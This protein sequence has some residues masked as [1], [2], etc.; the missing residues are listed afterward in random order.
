MIHLRLLRLLPVVIVVATFALFCGCGKTPAP[1]PTTSTTVGPPTLPGLA[2]RPAPADPKIKVDPLVAP[3]KLS[4][5]VVCWPAENAREE[6]LGISDATVVVTNLGEK[7]APQANVQPCV[8]TDKNGFFQSP[9]PSDGEYSVVVA[10]RGGRRYLP[11]ELPVFS[12]RDGKPHTL[13]PVVLSDVLNEDEPLSLR[14]VHGKLAVVAATAA[15]LTEAGRESLMKEYISWRD[16]VWRVMNEPRTVVVP[17]YFYPDPKKLEDWDRILAAAEKYKDRI[18]FR[19]ILNPNSGPPKDGQLDANYEA[20][21]KRCQSAHVSLLGYLAVA[22]QGDAQKPGWQLRTKQLSDDLKKWQKVHAVCPLDG[23]FLDNLPTADEKTVETLDDYLKPM[24]LALGG[25][26]RMPFFLGNPGQSE[27]V[28][29]WLK[30]KNKMIDNLCVYESSKGF[31]SF[32]LP[33][34]ATRT[35]KVKDTSFLA[36]GVKDVRTAIRRTRACMIQGCNVFYVTDATMQEKIDGLQWGRLPTYWEK[37]L[38]GIADNGKA[39]P[40]KAKD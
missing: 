9:L 34:W 33:D 18:R 20:I 4:G 22:D 16:D 23:L 39:P 21:A 19:V 6:L 36:Y 13:P 29:E 17:A 30:S 31:D 7:G 25:G 12:T 10:V 1:T 35:G 8:T 3:I 14:Q 11:E 15:D 24:R 40:I 2:V 5:R 27:K 38:A 28:E 37:W 26:G 32:R